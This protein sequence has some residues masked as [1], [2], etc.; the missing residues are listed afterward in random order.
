M[1]TPQIRIQ[2]SNLLFSSVSETER[3]IWTEKTKRPLQSFDDI[4]VYAKQLSQSWIEYESIILEAI[5]SLYG[6][7]FKKP[8]I[9]IYVSP[10]NSSISNPMIIN[11]G[12]PANIQIETVIHELLHVLFTDNTSFSM[13][14]DSPSVKLIDKWRELFGHDLAWKTLVHIPV[15]AGLKSIFLD[16]L[17]A[18]ERL[19]RDIARH[20]NNPIYKAAWDYVEEHDYKEINEKLKT[21]YVQLHEAKK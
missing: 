17:D 13:H 5:L 19:E 7:E 21:L 8:V 14:D 2:S 16:A 20:Q 11:P 6:V 10:W 18:P 3:K 4:E 15:H 12:R 1:N 9:D